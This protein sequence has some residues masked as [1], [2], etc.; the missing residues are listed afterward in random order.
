M[1]ESLE[2]LYAIEDIECTNQKVL[3]TCT[4]RKEARLPYVGRKRYHRLSGL[5]DLLSAEG[6]EV[7]RYKENRPGVRFASTSSGFIQDLDTGNR[8]VVC[9][10]FER[11][12]ELP[13]G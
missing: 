4:S 1:Y 3:V 2:I 6:N 8:R 10:R 7:T 13:L 11:Q 12:V 5:A 9:D